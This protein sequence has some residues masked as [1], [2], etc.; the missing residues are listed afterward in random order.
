MSLIY[1]ILS[2]FK[3]DKA[4]FKELTPEIK[5]LM[6]FRK[7]LMSLQAVDRFLA[8]S[9]YVYLRDKYAKIY[10]FY[11]NTLRANTLD[12]YCEQN[13]LERGYVD[14]FLSEEERNGIS[15]RL[16]LERGDIV[17]FQAGEP[18]MVNAALGNLRVYLGHH[19]GLIPEDTYNFLWVTDFP[20]FE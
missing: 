17:F 16:G 10:T 1:K 15:A 18:S 4:D 19:L 6:A 14:K 2:I 11:E 13:A 7:D 20:L 9:D 5:E 8:Q 12:Y 3:S